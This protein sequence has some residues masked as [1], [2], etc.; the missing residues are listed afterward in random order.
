MLHGPC[1]PGCLINISIVLV[2]AGHQLFTDKQ[3]DVLDMVFGLE[4]GHCTKVAHE[5]GGFAALLA[6][7]TS[8][9][10][11]CH[12][13]SPIRVDLSVVLVAKCQKVCFHCIFNTVYVLENWSTDSGCGLQCVINTVHQGR[14]HRCSVYLLSL[15]D[16][17]DN[18]IEECLVGG[19]L[20]WLGDM[21]ERIPNLCTICST[22]LLL[23][24]AK[25]V[26][27]N[28]CEASFHTLI[29]NVHEE[30]RGG[31]ADILDRCELLVSAA[32]VITDA[33][34]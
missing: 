29:L 9:F 8:L 26:W 24:I 20:E 10:V 7:A 30:M 6:A 19:M 23:V 12:G 25:G 15:E 4:A 16:R 14:Y 3:H 2:L 11:I 31:M 17:T 27:E 13:F 28:Q 33:Y 5:L 21:E 34:C 1:R 22:L 18:S 32:C